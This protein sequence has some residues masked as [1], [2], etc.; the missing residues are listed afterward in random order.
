MASLTHWKLTTIVSYLQLS[1]KYLLSFSS[2]FASFF[3]PP[4]W[5]RCNPPQH[6][7]LSP[8]P[9]GA[10]LNDE[11]VR[12]PNFNPVPSMG[13]S[14]VWENQESS[15]LS[16]LLFTPSVRDTPFLHLSASTTVTQQTSL[17]YSQVQNTPLDLSN[18]TPQHS[19]GAANQIHPLPSAHTPLFSPVKRYFKYLN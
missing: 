19:D 14:F 13:H 4:A 12:M 6:L 7:S 3:Y 15:K 5:Y 9:Q 8:S 2:F 18:R 17:S 10:N 1:V 11:V 16:P